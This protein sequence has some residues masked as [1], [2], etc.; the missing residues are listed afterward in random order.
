MLGKLLKYD[1]KSCFK[2]WWIIAIV[3]LVMAVF[4]GIC[5]FI[6]DIDLEAAFG[7]EVELPLTL[8]LMAEFG[9]LMF[10]MVQGLFVVAATVL[11]FIR[12]Y[13]NFFTDEGYLTFTLPV[14]RTTLLNSKIINGMIVLTATLIVSAIGLNIWF[15]MTYAA[16]ALNGYDSFYFS[17]PDF[18]DSTFIDILQLV[19]IAVEMLIILLMSVYIHNLFVYL[20]GTFAAVITRKARV[21]T[22]IGIYYVAS[23]VVSFVLQMLLCFGIV[24]IA[25][26]FDGFSEV[27]AAWMSI[28]MLLCF[29]LLGW[30]VSTLLYIIE[31]WMLDRKLNMA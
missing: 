7:L 15:G 24:S 28:L 14:K 22:A 19:I 27:N 1:L 12:L 20:C 21:I 5:G 29:I 18:S 2:F 11:I 23:N 8:N 16:S 31:Y 10:F 13:R 4:G 30:I 26:W 25:N 3:Y 9:S 6:A 17:T